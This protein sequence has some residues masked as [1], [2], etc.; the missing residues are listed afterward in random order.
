MAGPAYQLLGAEKVSF[1]SADAA[2]AAS[3]RVR[4]QISPGARRGLADSLI[5][6]ILGVGPPTADR[7]VPL[8]AGV[9]RSNALREALRGLFVAPV[10]ALFA[11]LASALA[12]YGG[13]RLVAQAIALIGVGIVIVAPVATGLAGA[14]AGWVRARRSWIAID[15]DC[16]VVHDGVWRLRTIAVPLAKVQAVEMVTDPAQRSCG[17]ATIMV[18][19]AGVSGRWTVRVTDLGEERV[20]SLA[21][22]IVRVATA[23]VLVDGV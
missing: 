3:E 1:A 13:E 19:I 16:L 11:S 5:E 21:A 7:C 9:V 23:V 20:R 14:F 22:D 4:T 17:T 18:D 8:G 10:V 6:P 12:V 2:V 15:D